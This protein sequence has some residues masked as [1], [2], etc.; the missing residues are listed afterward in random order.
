[1]LALIPTLAQYDR[2]LESTQDECASL[3]LRMSAAVF[4]EPVIVW[5]PDRPLQGRECESADTGS[6]HPAARR[7]H[8]QLSGT[9]LT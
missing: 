6:C 7:R 2:C 3:V 4:K 8:R 5:T 1:M 9:L